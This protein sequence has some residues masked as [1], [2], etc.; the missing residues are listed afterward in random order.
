MSQSVYKVSNKAPSNTAWLSKTRSRSNQPFDCHVK[1]IHIPARA[2]FPKEIIAALVEPARESVAPEVENN[3]TIRLYN[4][5]RPGRS[6]KARR[7]GHVCVEILSCNQ[8]AVVEATRIIR[9]V[10][11]KYVWRKFVAC[12]QEARRAVTGD[13][14]QKLKQILRYARDHTH[15]SFDRRA[16]GFKVTSFT[17]K[18]VEL[19]AIKIHEAIRGYHAA[20]KERRQRH[21]KRRVV[22][23]KTLRLGTRYDALC[24][25]TDS[26]E[27][28]E[29]GEDV[30]V[31]EVGTLA[32]YSRQVKCTHSPT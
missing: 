24:N 16:C 23:T 17:S 12:P 21:R 4:N 2:C 9:Q 31:A 1:K 19:A 22:K 20:K 27:E 25:D 18:G 6:A 28:D 10:C 5:S 15:I 3:I 7:R 29:P 32:K 11:D 14:N 8:T 30:L 26:E 13:H